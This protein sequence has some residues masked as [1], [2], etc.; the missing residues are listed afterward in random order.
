MALRGESSA[1]MRGVP[2]AWLPDVRWHG[3]ECVS[4]HCTLGPRYKGSNADG[5]LIY[6]QSPI[7]YQQPCEVRYYYFHSTA[8]ERD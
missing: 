5:L 3:T 4:N 6:Y 2:R 7:Y 8:Q 1:V